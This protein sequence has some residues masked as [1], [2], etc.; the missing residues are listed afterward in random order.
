MR[1]KFINRN[2]ELNFLESSWQRGKF[3]LIIVYGRRRVGKTRL[4]K[5]FSKGKKTIY[6]L[7]AEVPYE[8]LCDE[9]SSLVRETVGIPVS[10]DIIEILNFLSRLK[11]R[12]LIILDEFQYIVEADKSFLSRLLR[13]IDEVLNESKLMIILCGSAV[14]FFERKLLGYKSPIFGRREGTIKLSSLKFKHIKEFF[15]SFRIDNLIEIYGMVGGTPAYLEKLSEAPLEENLRKILTPGM[16]LYDEAINLLRQEV[17]EPRTYLA[18]LSA[19]AE[20]K[21]SMGEISSRAKVDPRT[22]G[23][24]VD[25]LEELEIIKRVNPLGFRKPV[26]L[27]FQDN[28]FR[29]WFTYV[30]RFRSPLEAGLVDEVLS[31]VIRTYNSYLSKVFENLVIEL[32][33][34]LYKGGIIKTKPLEFGRWW[35]KDLEIDCIVREPGKSTTFIEIKW[36]RLKDSE[37]IREL[38]DLETKSLKSGLMSPENF[39]ILITKELEEHKIK[40]DERRMAIDIQTIERI[41]WS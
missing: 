9:F 25:L 5:E 2:Y 14:S 27:E 23:K 4:L 8:Q 41:L 36:K 7:A 13:A 24:Y 31:Y 30:F 15:P 33:P 3:S 40:L 29:F 17:R 22:I 11:E 37:A 26:K 16:Y 18:I 19:I 6:F 21:N 1:R 32:V 38:K 39:Y 20:G 35:H 10:G 12:Y 28:Y 34:E